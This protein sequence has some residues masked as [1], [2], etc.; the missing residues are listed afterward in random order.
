MAYSSL[1][2][3]V[4]MSPCK[5]S[6]RNHIIDTIT[7]HCM[8]F[9]GS[10]EACGNVFQTS[11]VYNARGECIDGSSS[12]YGIGPD[13]RI[14]CYVDEN[15]RS[16]CSGGSK[17]GHEASRLNDQRAITIEVACDRDP[18]YK[19][20]NAALASLIALLVDICYRN[21]IPQ[22]RWKGDP[23][24]IG[25]VEK[26]NMTV[27]RWFAYKACPGDYLYNLHGQIAE[28][29]NRQL[30][31]IVGFREKIA[32]GNTGGGLS[33]GQTGNY[34]G[35]SNSNY[36]YAGNTNT[37]AQYTASPVKSS[38]V[39]YTS[40]LIAKNYEAR[41]NMRAI[42]G[43]T[44]HIAWK[45]GNLDDLTELLNNQNKSYNYGIGSDGKIGTF[46]DENN[47]TPS[48]GNAE[49]DNRCVNIVCMNDSD[50]TWSISSACYN[51][52]VV[53]CADICKRNYI[54]RL[55]YT[56]NPKSDS[57]T[58]HCDFSNSTTCPGPYLTSRWG[59]IVTAVNHRIE[60]SIGETEINEVYLEALKEMNTVSVQNTHPYVVKI[61]NGALHVD[62]EML[63]GIGVIGVMIDAGQRYDEMHNEVHYRNE[64]VYEQADEAIEANLP[65]GFFYTTHAR[66]EL[67]VKEE[68]WWFYYV[69][70]KYPPKLGAW[71]HCQFDTDEEVAAELVDKWYEYLV[72]WGL[73]AKCGLYC[74][75]EQAEL[76]G[77]PR[78]STYM[79]LWLEQ[80]ATESAAPDEEM[81]VP[82]FYSWLYVA[83]KTL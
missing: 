75:H 40:K 70:S 30:D 10:I 18:P 63:K 44:I 52:L 47:S 9:P 11:A 79:N 20:T 55:V 2:S 15:D 53:L 56:G 65:Y 5:S 45:T 26:Q 59:D 73:K 61:T 21:N 67:E 3:Y 33:G 74:T 27:H 37:G 17:I 60:S 54:S 69:V 48:T 66:T 71:I 4:K 1:V 43:I 22:L 28:S 80:D 49:N 6:P 68:A 35:S 31:N 12:N 50:Q 42:T 23:K 76:I 14:G 77:W 41:G 72:K 8:A 78:Q 82:S 36:G 34:S 39:D 62:Y 64:E 38:T 24:L 57:L 25:Q 46:V 58:K 7:I 19:V 29:V 16:W 32:K 81:L 83:G 13:G 51:S